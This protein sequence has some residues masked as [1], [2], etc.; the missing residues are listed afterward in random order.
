MREDRDGLLHANIPMFGNYDIID[1][2]LLEQRV[3][4]MCLYTA[5][6]SIFFILSFH[7]LGLAMPESGSRTFG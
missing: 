2:I 6:F 1:F 4:W 3:D 5:I 7:T